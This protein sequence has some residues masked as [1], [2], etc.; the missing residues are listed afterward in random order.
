VGALRDEGYAVAAG[1]P[2]R[3]SP[4]SAIRVTTATLEPDEAPRLAAAIE[5]AVSPSR[6][7]RTA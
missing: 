1:T 3:L 7:T 6:R 4:G 2:Y 5:R